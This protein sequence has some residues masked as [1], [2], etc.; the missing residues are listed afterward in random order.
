M[1]CFFLFFGGKK[2]VIWCIDRAFLL[3]FILHIAPYCSILLHIVVVVFLVC[4]HGSR[5]IEDGPGGTIQDSGIIRAMAGVGN[6]RIEC[7]ILICV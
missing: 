1:R 2:N 3:I 7:I 4:N 5:T 6:G